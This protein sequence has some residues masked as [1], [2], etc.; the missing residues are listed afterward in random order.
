MVCSSSAPGFYLSPV[1]GAE[2]L[3]STPLSH[4]VYS[5]LSANGLL[6]SAFTAILHILHH[7]S[8][9]LCVVPDV[10]PYHLNPDINAGVNI[11]RSA[12]NISLDGLESVCTWF[13]VWWDK[14]LPPPNFVVLASHQ[15]DHHFLLTP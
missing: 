8:P 11:W 5:N 1:T 2:N 10:V 7:H 3:S 6:Y 13:S 15:H 9:P 4:P 12:L 14:P